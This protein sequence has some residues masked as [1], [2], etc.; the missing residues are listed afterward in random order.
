MKYRKLFMIF[1]ILL[2]SVAGIT[3]VV[4][5][6]KADEEAVVEAFGQINC[7]SMESS[8]HVSGS[9][10]SDYLTADEQ[11]KLLEKIA[12]GIGITQNYEILK[13]NN[14][15]S[16]TVKLEKNS[17][18]A[19]VEMKIMT[20]EDEVEDNV[21]QTRQYVEIELNMYKHTE[22]ILVLKKEIE[23]VMK[24][25]PFDCDVGLEFEAE[26][27][28]ELSI[29]EKNRLSKQFLDNISANL[30]SEEKSEE[31]YTIYAYTELISDYEAV[32]GNA[33]NVNLVFSYDE[34]ENITSFYMATPYLLGEY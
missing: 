33:V 8:F 4:Q 25:T 30:V 9:L 7:Q 21:I 5:L 31:I 29:A 13:E 11:Q 22:E 14:S 23:K 3:L 32:D 26:F 10:K 28:R 24:D 15:R 12:N 16:R 18:C 17:D 1:V 20:Y 27:N 34:D 2:W 19:D 6:N